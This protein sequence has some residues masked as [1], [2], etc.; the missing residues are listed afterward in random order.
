MGRGRTYDKL[1]WH[2]PEGK[3]CPSLDTAKIHFDVVMRWLETRELLSP[4]GREATEIGIDSDFALTSQMA[5]D[6]GNRVLVAC[7]A[8]WVRRVKYGT[9][10]SVKSLEDCLQKIRSGQ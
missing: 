6:M 4:E 8:D 1:S 9:R 2:F 5:T 3:E 10:P 7:Y